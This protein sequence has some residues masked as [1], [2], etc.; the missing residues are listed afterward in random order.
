MQLDSGIWDESPQVISVKETVHLL[1]QVI[2]KLDEND[3]FS[4]QIMVGVAVHLLQNVQ[5]ELEQHQQIERMLREVLNNS[6]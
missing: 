1:S 2:Q 6:I 5:S 3:Y 4:A